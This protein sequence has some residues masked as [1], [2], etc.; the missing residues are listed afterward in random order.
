MENLH[1][2]LK[3]IDGKAYKAYKEI[4]GEYNF[5]N[6]ILKI[7]HVQGDPFANPS[8]FEISFSLLKF[9]FSPEF[10]NTNSRKVAFEDYILRTIFEYLSKLSNKSISIYK[11]SQEILK[12]SCVEINSE[13]IKIKFYVCLPAKG[14]RVLAKETIEIVETQI[15]SLTDKIKK[16]NE[17]KLEAH[18]IL[19]ENANLFRNKLKELGIKVFI[20]NNS[21]L[22]RKNAIDDSPLKN[23][24]KFQAPQNLEETISLKNGFSLT[25]MAIRDGVTI[26]TGGGFHGKT[27]LLNAIEKGIYNHIAG[28]GREY[29]FTTEDA[30]KVRTENGR[31]VNKVNISSFIKNLPFKKDTVEFTTENAS[32]STSQASNIIEALEL[33]CRLLLIDEDTSATN[34]LLRDKKITEL[35]SENHEPI[36]PFISRV[37]GMYRKNGISTILVIGGLGEYFHVADKVL[38]MENYKLIDAT[39]KARNIIKKYETISIIDKKIEFNQ[40]YFNM[41]ETIKIFNTKKVKIKNKGLND[42]FIGKNEVDLKYIEQIVENGQINFIG[43]LLRKIFT[44]RDL[45]K[46]N[47]NDILETY[48]RRLENENI[49]DLLG[50]EHA[51]LVYAR[52]F[53]VAS[54]I[55]RIRQNIIK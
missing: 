37:Q 25:G 43:E 24:I 1:T 9:G 28:D 46:L 35:I 17:K 44:R 50:I 41:V 52:K 27:T 40:R 23:A 49:C 7:L 6:Y 48:N 53:E 45:E 36:T 31:S 10:F 12:R 47:I 13:I 55:N 39:E 26:L 16:I 4:L 2:L 18:I 14:R 21:I 15:P 29:V 22:P 51:S 34:F 54:A 38:L 8:V 19:N 3:R 30:V 33:G 5:N 42:L 11:P 32:G 20:G